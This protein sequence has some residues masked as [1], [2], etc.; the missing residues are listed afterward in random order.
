MASFAVTTIQGLLTELSEWRLRKRKIDEGLKSAEDPY[1]VVS[2]SEYVERHHEWWASRRQGWQRQQ[3]QCDVEARTEEEALTE[4]LIGHAVELERHAR[5][6]LVTHLPHG[7]KGQIVLKADRMVQL[8][9]LQ[10]LERQESSVDQQS[11]RG[12]QAS[13][14]L[15]DDSDW[16]SSLADGEGTMEGIR[17]YREAFAAFLA[18]GSRLRK[19]E[20]AEKYKAERRLMMSEEI[21]GGPSRRQVVENGGEPKG[22]IVS[23]RFMP[24]KAYT[25]CDVNDTGAL[26]GGT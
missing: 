21:E 20:G 5:R 10:M 12:K 22:V 1:D 11:N 3:E 26:G 25:N 13:Q 4:A 18:M 6:L 8:K 17:R 24:H 15:A 2:H 16:I 19:L 14:F 7:S 9:H 23:A